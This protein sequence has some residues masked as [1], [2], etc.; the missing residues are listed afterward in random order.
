VKKIELLSPARNAESGIAAISCGADAVYI[1]AP[2]FGARAAAGNSIED[3]EQLCN[4]AHRYY[5]RVYVT[6]NTI[7]YDQELSEAQNI[8][9][10]L[11]NIGVDALIIQDMSL[12]QMSLPPIPLF[13]STQTHNYDIERIKFLEDSG[14]QRVILARELSIKQITEISQACKVELES[15]VHGALCVS[16]SGQCYMSQAVTGRSA[17]RGECAQL[18][19]SAYSLFDENQK[20][21]A[22]DKHLLSLKDLNLSEYLLDMMNA[23]I[24]SFKI[25]GRLK[26]LAYVKNITSFYRQKLDAILNTTNQYS[27]ASSGATRF[28]FT[29]DPEKS[30]SRGY[31]S[32]FINGRQKD[33][34]SF[35]TPKAIGKAVAKVNSCDKGSLQLSVYETIA[36]GDGLC[37]FD[38]GQLTGFMANKLSNNILYPNKAN[39]TIA[40][41]TL[42]YRNGDKKFREMMEKPVSERKIG[43]SFN[44]DIQDN[45]VTLTAI[46]EDQNSATYQ[47][48][49]LATKAQ[50]AAFAHENIRRQLSKTGNS[51]FTVIQIDISPDFDIFLTASFLNALRRETLNTLENNR[52]NNRPILK[53]GERKCGT[54]FQSE[55]SYKANVSNKLAE[56]FYQKCGVKSIE[57]AFELQTNYRDKTVM[58]TRHC[59]RFELGKCLKGKAFGNATN[60]YLE[61]NNH[62]YELAFDCENCNMNIILKK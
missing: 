56:V 33:I 8:I 13:A 10:Q 40:P 6:L 16:L 3:I 46:D 23:G 17:N 47:Q 30:F 62:K 24:T 31:T 53:A 57:P 35:N 45:T 14:I 36:P 38:K 28:F 48:T 1:G 19:R 29:P 61:D 26:D 2:R 51:V 54:Y 44:I 15:F 49:C 12:M 11:Y 27:K 4:F 18:C 37:F 7:L 22:K 60:W 32:Y 59:L 55:L 25:E 39:I 21:L 58:T 20:L 9:N 42:L 50:N 52:I 5:A 34:A 43:V 41:G